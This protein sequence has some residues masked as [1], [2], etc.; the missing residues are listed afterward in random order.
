MKQLKTNQSGFTLVEIIVSTAIF[1]IVVA[2]VLVLFNSVL[3]INKRVQ[4]TR[5][6]AQAS[7]NLTET[8]SRE[9]RNGRIEYPTDN[10]CPDLDYTKVENRSLLISSYTGEKICFYYNPGLRTIFIRRTTTAGVTE[11]NIIPSN[12]HVKE[13]LKFVVRPTSDPFIDN[14]GIQPMVTVL[15]DFV[16]D[17]ATSD[18]KTISYQSS[19]STDVYDIPHQ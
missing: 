6:L 16:I 7:R 4:S 11:D 10:N 1:T 2:A 9:V 8:L 5:Q 17:E 3:H 19:I 12:I 13:T 14:K 18:E 15:A